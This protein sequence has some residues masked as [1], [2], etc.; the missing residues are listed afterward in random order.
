MSKQI[1]V[2]CP[3]LM[4]SRTAVYLWPEQSWEMLEFLTGA[5]DAMTDHLTHMSKARPTM[6]HTMTLG[7]EMRVVRATAP[8]STE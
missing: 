7:I 2:V 5:L 4:G 8:S 6:H 3:V 1:V